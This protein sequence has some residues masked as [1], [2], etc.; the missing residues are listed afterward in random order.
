MAKARIDKKSVMLNEMEGYLSSR[1]NF[2]YNEVTGKIEYENIN[3][4]VPRDIT[5]RV[6]NDMIREIRK[7]KGI[8][9]TDMDIYTLLNSSFSVDYNPLKQYFST[10]PKWDEQTDYIQALADTVGVL[11]EERELWNVYLRRWLI[12]YVGCAIDD[13]V[14]N[15]S[16]LIF[17]G[18]QG[19]GKT[20]WIENLMPSILR[21]KYSYKG[22]I[23]PND[24]DSEVR[25]AEN[26]LINLDE[27]ESLK[28]NNIGDMKR[29]ITQSFIKVRKPYA[30]CDIV[31]PRRASLAGSVNHPEFLKDGTGNRRYLVV[32]AYAFK[33]NHGI[34][35][36]DVLSQAYHLFLQ[37]EK[38]KFDTQQEIKM[39]EKNN[40][41]YKY[42]SEELDA[43][44]EY[45]APCEKG[46]R[47]N[48]IFNTVELIS[49]LKKMNSEIY[50]NPITL[51]K[52]M[53]NSNFERCRDKP[54]GTRKWMLKIRE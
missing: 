10:L 24:K 2:R 4:K 7:V 31:M 13:K 26:M 45:F 12:A 42:Q 36:E 48:L 37:G 53:T 35:I 15:E 32:T 46:E 16:V 9:V 50:L 17:A 1:Y 27:L 47:P 43:V 39:I 41:K 21:K 5:D 3:E 6:V 11:D 25:M 19:L 51:G 54:G 38:Y 28:G 49:Y 8:A 14:I 18:A 52:A 40:R 29:L 23:N 20:T 34:E 30:K 33:R 22:R 44:L